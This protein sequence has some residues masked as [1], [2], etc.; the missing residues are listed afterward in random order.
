MLLHNWNQLVK[1]ILGMQ[2]NGTIPLYAE[3]I[4]Q[5]VKKKHPISHYNIPESGRMYVVHLTRTFKSLQHQR[6]E[7]LM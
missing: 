7:P 4:L 2:K 1:Q 5:S 6:K 3:K